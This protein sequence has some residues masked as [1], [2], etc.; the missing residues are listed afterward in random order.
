MYFP[1]AFFEGLIFGVT[2]IRGL[3]FGG[4]CPERSLRFKI[5]WASL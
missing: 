1:K 2:Y 3:I 5:D 4:L